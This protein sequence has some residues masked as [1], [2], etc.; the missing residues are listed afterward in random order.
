MTDVALVWDTRTGRADVAI[1][2]GD[3]LQD[4]GLLTSVLISLFSWARAR[5]EDVPE[6][7]A[8]Q[9]W[10]LDDPADPVGSKLWLVIAGK[11]SEANLG[12][13]RRYAEAALAWLVEDGVAA[14]VEV[15][16][17][18]PNERAMELVPVIVTPDGERVSGRFEV[19]SNGV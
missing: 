5:D 3:L 1:E 19:T 13:A 4:K 2:G 14:S 16:A 9:G 7:L 11:H 10:C 15:R 18:Y 6:G 17:S 12:R 8:N